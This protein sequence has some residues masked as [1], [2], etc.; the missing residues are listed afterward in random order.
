MNDAQRRARVGIYNRHWS[1]LGGGETQA[2]G[3]VDAL[4]D[5]YDVTLIGPSRIDVDLARERLGVRLEGVNFQLVDDYQATVS[6]VSAEYDLFINHTYRSVE[7]SLARR[8]IYFV[9]FPHELA[10]ESLSQ[11][12]L[13]TALGGR[14]APARLSSGVVLDGGNVALV[15]AALIVAKPGVTEVELMFDTRTPGSVEVAQPFAP[16]S[17]VDIDGPTVVTVPTPRGYGV[18]A[19]VGRS[20]GFDVSFAPRIT[21]LRVAGQ[22]IA[23]NPRS[24]EQRLLRVP[25]NAFLDT[26]DAVSANSEYTGAWT[27][28]WWGV[29]AEV[30]TP[31]VRMRTPGAKEQLILSVG[32]FFGEAGG[33][34]KRQLEMVEAFRRLCQQGVEGWRLVLIGGSSAADREYAM[35]VRVAAQGLPIE[36]RFSAPG[37]VLDEHFERA[38]IYWHA[39]GLGADLRKN[40]EQAEHF[41]IA[42]VEAMSAGAVPVVFDAAGPASVVTHGVDGLKYSTID[43]L[44]SST[45]QLIDD[46]ALRERLAQKA[47]ARSSDFDRAHFEQHVRSFVAGVLE[48]PPGRH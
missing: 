34:S 25:A 7:P 45:R 28:R 43:G 23:A 38:A 15:D 14:S 24:L 48:R 26:Y 20:E 35:A 3:V 29:D 39:A 13:R 41:G 4:S 2:F 10:G 40:P 21:G 44:V 1:T 9:M 11:S 46:P 12:L 16:P 31:P 19:V 33:H 6:M 5:L 32:R 22:S 27:K 18:V 47:T 30:I 42:P 36:I 8:G 37:E 17:V